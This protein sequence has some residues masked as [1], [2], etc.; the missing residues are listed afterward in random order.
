MEVGGIESEAST[1]S[2]DGVEGR[3][4]AEKVLRTAMGL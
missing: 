1:T 2:D 3:D 4:V